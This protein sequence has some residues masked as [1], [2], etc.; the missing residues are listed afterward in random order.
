M[1]GHD[2]LVITM[3]VQAPQDQQSKLIAAAGDAGIPWIFPNEY[4]YSDRAGTDAGRDVFLGP[5]YLA[6]RQQIEALPNKPSWIAICCGFWYEYSLGL[7]PAYGIDFKNKTATFYDDGETKINTSTFNRVSEGVAALLSLPVTREDGNDKSP[8]LMDFRN[9]PCRVSS[10]YVCQK[11]MFAS[12]VRVTGTKEE[13]WK[14]SYQPAKER[15]E[16]GQKEMKEGN[17]MGYVKLLYGRCFFKDGNGTFEDKKHNALLGLKDEDL[18]EATK[19][20]MERAEKG[21][22]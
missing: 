4:G 15:F 13:D 17:G 2:V 12:A 20:A 5:R 3:S 14:I 21:I 7:A 1:K 6:A 19:I 22:I 10:F 11:D 18:D 9:S 8:C 16:E